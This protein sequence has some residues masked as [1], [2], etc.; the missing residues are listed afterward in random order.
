MKNKYTE[1]KE[2]IKH[3][4]APYSKFKVAAIVE[5]DIGDFPGVNVEN[6]SYPL[7]VCA[8]RNAI[9]A[10][11]VA[12]A[13]KVKAVHVL[14]SLSKDSLTPCGACRQVIAE[15]SDESTPLYMYT[16]TGKVKKYTLKQLLP[17]AFKM[18]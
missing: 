6:A 2:I 12:G 11:I 1:L 3:A 18:Q 4:Y 9:A 7:A 13:K 14:S 8:E 16:S 15:F 5:T 10:A 17:F